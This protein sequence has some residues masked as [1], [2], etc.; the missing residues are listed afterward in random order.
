MLLTCAV[1]FIPA[2]A[3]DT[4]GHVVRDCR[5]AVHSRACG[6]HLICGHKHN[7]GI[8]SSPR[9]RGTLDDHRV[10][11]GIDRFIPAHAGDT[12]RKALE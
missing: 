8:G 3:G 2:H 1:L 10:D 7:W 5:H 6:G 11:I 12:A 9:M 4:S